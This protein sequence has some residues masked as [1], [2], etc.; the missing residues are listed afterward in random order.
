MTNIIF[1]ASISQR[2]DFLIQFFLSSTFAIFRVNGGGGG[3]T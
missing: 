3:V 2:E 1:N